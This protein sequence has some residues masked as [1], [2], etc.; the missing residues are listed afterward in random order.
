[1]DRP[2]DELIGDADDIALAAV[3]AAELLVGVELASARRRAG[4]AAY[5]DEAL[6]RIPIESYD[7]GV[8]R[9]H[10]SLLAHTHR[11]GTPR[12]AHD[13]IIAATA[14]ARDRIVVSADAR[15]FA[16]LPGVAVRS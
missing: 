1:L 14:L 15:G 2:L 3:T 12:G 13:L 6:A 5:V 10:A 11:T 9:A 7:L 4:R 16:G 8:A